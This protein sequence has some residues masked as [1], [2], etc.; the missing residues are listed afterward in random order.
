MNCEFDRAI[1]SLSD[2]LKRTFEFIPQDIKQKC[3]EIRLRAG[4]PVCIT[5]RGRTFFI[6]KDGYV[7]DVLQK[8][9]LKAEKEDI[10][11]TALI[12][13]SGFIFLYE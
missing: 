13:Y 1:L 5:V 9:A 6:E 12:Y 3:E 10:K 8:N 2:N 4:L 7:T 11:Q